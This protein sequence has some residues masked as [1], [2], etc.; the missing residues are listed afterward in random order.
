MDNNLFSRPKTHVQW[1]LGNSCNYSCSYCHEMFRRGDRDKVDSELLLE[2]CKDITYHYDE[3]GRDVVFEFLGGEP[4]LQER[5][6]EIGQR[7]SN[8]P[9]NL[10]LRTN[11]SAPLEWW[12]KVKPV[13][14]GVII[15]VHREFADIDHIEKVIEF[16][17]DSENVYPMENIQI[18]FPVTHVPESF[19]WGVEQVKK[20]RKRHDLGEL[21]LLYSDFG[22]GSSMYMP[23][24]PDQ[25]AIYQEI[26]NIKPTPEKLSHNTSHKKENHDTL[27][28]YQPI[29]T[30]Q[31]CFAGIETLT[32]DSD[33]NVWRGW[34]RQDGKLGN[35]HNLPI[36]WP[37][38]PTICQKS[39]CHNGFDRQA[40][41]EI[42]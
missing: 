34:C 5:I 35:I 40:T 12:K 1:M 42:I 4:T 25:W 21:Q 11:G 13:I 20:F 30:D 3:L 10:I 17:R 9:T 29:F 6:P 37:K 41:K 14:G 36:D 31:R 8:F 33:G 24:K 23:Y 16:L 39:F 7:L 28:R 27:R 26:N 38:E 22:R 15:S 18:L 32:I 19:N 2:V